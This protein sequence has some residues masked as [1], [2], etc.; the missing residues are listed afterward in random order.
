V[1][2]NRGGAPTQGGV[3]KFPGGR[4]PL[5]SLQHGKVLNGN[6]YLPNVTPV[7]ILRRYMLFGLVPEE[8]RVGVKFLEVLQA[9]AR[10]ASQGFNQGNCLVGMPSPFDNNICAFLAFEKSMVHIE[11]QG[12]RLHRRAARLI[13]DEHECI[14]F[15]Q[16]RASWN[17]TMAFCTPA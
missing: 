16:L 12:S 17:T 9:K 5:D 2:L 3:K 10:P 6:V 8:M 1:V 13:P 11:F 15:A 14:H 7:L 4:G